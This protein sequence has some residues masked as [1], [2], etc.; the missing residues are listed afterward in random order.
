LPLT[1]ILI[2]TAIGR[3]QASEIHSV[4][5]VGP[6]F[7]MKK[8]DRITG[9]CIELWNEIATLRKVK[10][11]YRV[12]PDVSAV[13]DAIGSKNADVVVVIGESSNFS[14]LTRQLRPRR[15]RAFWRVK[16][17]T[18]ISQAESLVGAQSVGSA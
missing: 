14:G 8:G 10:R 5:M 4:T 3:N 2:A 6:F 11:T 18:R 9:F 12:A 7:V 13:L 17:C 16:Y 15:S 1:V